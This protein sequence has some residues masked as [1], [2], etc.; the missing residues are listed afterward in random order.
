MKIL[1]NGRQEEEISE[2]HSIDTYLIVVTNCHFFAHVL[3]QLMIA[4]ISFQKRAV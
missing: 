1:W 4:E 3:F 2:D